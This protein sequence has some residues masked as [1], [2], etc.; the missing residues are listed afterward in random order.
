MTA[1]YNEA[2]LSILPAHRIAVRVIPRKLFCGEPISASRV[3]ALWQKRDYAS[4]APLVPETT[5]VYIREHA[6]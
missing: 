3:R 5:L 4:I 1:A 6:L 2:L